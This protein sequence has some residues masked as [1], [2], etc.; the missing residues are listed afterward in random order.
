MRWIILTKETLVNENY[1]EIYRFVAEY[2]KKKKQ[3]IHVLL[4]QEINLKYLI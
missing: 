2:Q 4:R 3:H 1:Q